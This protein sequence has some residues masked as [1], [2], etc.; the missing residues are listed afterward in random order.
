MTDVDTQEVSRRARV[1]FPVRLRCLSVSDLL[2]SN[3]LEDG[4]ARA[5]GL[6]KDSRVDPLKARGAFQAW[7]SAGSLRAY[8]RSPWRT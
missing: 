2:T 7:L 4:V 8:R 5:A 1:A 6:L 3:E